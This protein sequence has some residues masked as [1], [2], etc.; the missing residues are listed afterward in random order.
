MEAVHGLDDGLPAQESLGFGNI[1]PGFFDVGDVEGLEVDD[2]LLAKGLLDEGD[3]GLERDGVVAATEIDDLVAKR[4]ERGDG[5]PGDI[6]DVGEVARLG[7]VAHQLEGLA[8]LDPLD[9]AEDAH[10]GPAGWAEDR[11][12]TDDRGVEAVE[13]EVAVGHE[14]G[15]LLGGGVRGEWGVDR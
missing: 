5:P 6:V 2:S 3:D 1:G 15:G 11:E 14:L 13:L 4:L 7:T 12:V 10:V 8:R 9:E